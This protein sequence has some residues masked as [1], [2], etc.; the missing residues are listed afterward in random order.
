MSEEEV[1]VAHSITAPAVG[2]REALAD[3]PDADLRLLERCRQGDGTAFETLFRKYQT[4]VYNISLGMLGNNEDAADITQEA[5]LRLHRS[6]ESF[7]GDSS[8]S[9]WLYRVAVNLCITE[10]RRRGRSRLQ[11]I[12]EM[13]QDE[14]APL[15]EE[16]GPSPDE[17]I[18]Q[19]EQRRVVHQVLRT[20]PADYRAIMVLRHFQQLAYEEIAQVLGLTLSQV[21]TRLFRARRMFKER[22][23]AFAGDQDAVS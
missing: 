19:E 3:V 23:H 14:E 9:T 20:L 11:F 21:K 8:F 15:H 12:E 2:I 7:R 22:F 13:R 4:Y 5:F 18:E 1:R 6:L 17:A 10:L 16:P